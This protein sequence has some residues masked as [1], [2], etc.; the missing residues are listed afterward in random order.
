[1]T[2]R[3]NQL[4]IEEHKKLATHLYAIQEHI[5]Q[6]LNI[7]GGKVPVALL[8]K[9]LSF[10]PIDKHLNDLRSKLEDLMSVENAAT[11]ASLSI[12]YGDVDASCAT[13]IVGKPNDFAC[14]A[15]KIWP[16]EEATAPTIEAS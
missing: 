8:D 9:L 3:K 14:E 10:K 12:Y 4:S 5:R 2:R 7:M 1:M 11:D 15:E 16:K 6:M 13:R